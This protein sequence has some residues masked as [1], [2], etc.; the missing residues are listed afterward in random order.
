MS[1]MRYEQMI[2]LI[3]LEGEAVKL[4]SSLSYLGI[5]LENKAEAL[6]IRPT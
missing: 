6:H 2:L 4:E 1:M 3:I 5:M